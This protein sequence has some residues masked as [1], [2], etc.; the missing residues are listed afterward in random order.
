MGVRTWRRHSDD[1]H[2]WTPSVAGL[3]DVVIEV[4]FDEVQVHGTTLVDS[5]QGKFRASLKLRTFRW[6][7]ISN[8]FRIFLLSHNPVT[9]A[10]VHGDCAC[11]IVDRTGL[12]P[13]RSLYL[14]ATVPV[15]SAPAAPMTSRALAAGAYPLLMTD[16]PL[17]CY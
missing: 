13:V 17:E 15:L 16:P 8:R 14:L 7:S 2:D 9:I 3:F 5:I 4:S 6:D 10:A 11:R 12:A 1:H